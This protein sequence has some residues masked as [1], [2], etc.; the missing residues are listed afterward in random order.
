MMGKKL[1]LDFKNTQ[2]FEIGKTPI[3]GMTKTPVSGIGDDAYYSTAR[4]IGTTLSVRKGSV[5]FIMTLHSG[6][7]ADRIKAREKDL[8]LQIL[9]KL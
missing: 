5:A 7:S 6:D 3:Q 8:A 1:T 9:K 2:S 4:G